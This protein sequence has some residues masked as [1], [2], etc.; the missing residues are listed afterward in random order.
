MAYPVMIGQLGIIMM[1]IV[2]SAMVGRIG[3]DPLAASSIANGLFILVL[4]IGI[5][6]SYVISPLVSIA[7]GSNNQKE[8]ESIFKQSFYVNVI[9]GFFLMLISFFASELVAYLNQPSEV[10]RLAIPYIRI[11]SISIIPVMVFQTYKQFIEGMSI[12]KPA[13]IITIA[14]NII[15]ALA[16]WVFIFGNLGLPAL[17]LNGAGLATLSSRTF[18]MA[19]IIIYV[20]RTS[21]L[22]DYRLSI[23]PIQLDKRMIVK[24]LSL[25]IPGGM[26]YFFEVGSFAFASVMIGWIGTI[27]LAAHQIALSLSSVSY[28]IILGISSAAAIRVGRFVG[29]KNIKE[30]RKAGFTALLLSASIMLFFGFIFITGKE[31]LPSLYIDNSEVISIASS[32]LIITAIFQV[33]DGTQATGIGI[34][35]G[36]TDMKIPTLI[37]FTSYWIIGLPSGYLFAFVFKAGVIGIWLGFLLCLITSALLL[38]L[39]FN[40]KSKQIIIH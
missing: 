27:E 19:G 38:T 29:E 3:A 14:A 40:Y 7:I 18:M 32:L 22:K 35:R 15:N 28:M 36:I 13:M 26:Q 4:I 9:L 10:E 16:N 39:R 5:G 20:I 33:F 17:G 24:I 8:C 6:V 1:G 31:L 12:M 25:G 2:D 37:T 23:L 21:T 34:L 11:L 30:T